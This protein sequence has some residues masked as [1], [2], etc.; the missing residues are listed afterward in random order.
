MARSRVRDI[1]GRLDLELSRPE[2]RE[3]GSHRYLLHRLPHALDLIPPPLRPACVPHRALHRGDEQPHEHLDDLAEPVIVVA[4][5]IQRPY[6]TL[7]GRELEDV[8]Y[9]ATAGVDHDTGSGR[10]RRRTTRR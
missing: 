5:E 9:E 1:P 3:P 8:D 4:I 10:R 6:L 7:V 2:T